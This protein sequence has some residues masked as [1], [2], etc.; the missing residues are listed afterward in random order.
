M[1]TTLFESLSAYFVR[2]AHDIFSNVTASS[3]LMSFVLVGDEVDL[4]GD[5]VIAIA[6]ATHHRQRG[7]K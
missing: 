4:L 2:K 6:V 1:I 7:A 3:A 5:G